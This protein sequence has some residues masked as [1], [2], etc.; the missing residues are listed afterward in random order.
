MPPPN[1]SP[2][3]R[4]FESIHHP[5]SRSWTRVV[6]GAL[7]RP[8]AATVLP[9]MIVV[10]TRALQL[11]VIWPYVAWGFPAALLVASAWT[12]FKLGR[13][14][15]EIRLQPGQAAVRSVHDVLVGARPDWQALH[16]VR[17]T[18]RSLT[19]SVGWAAFE[20]A[21]SEWPR[22]EALQNALEAARHGRDPEREAGAAR[23]SAPSFSP[24]SGG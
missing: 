2:S 22:F 12:R 14:I 1:S 5:G 21:G 8:I 20:L 4:T 6:G 10:T 15:A 13:Q 16:D 3:V 11:G 9:V 19:V 18:A 17:V 7:V 24:H 23:Q